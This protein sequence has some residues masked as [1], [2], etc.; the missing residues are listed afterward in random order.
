MANLMIN[1]I[2]L[3]ENNEIEFAGKLPEN[4]KK[5][6]GLR[7]MTDSQLADVGWLPM[8]EIKTDYNQKTHYQ[9]TPIMDIQSDKIVFTDDIVAYTAQELKRNKYSDW[10]AKI[11]MSDTQSNV[12]IDGVEVAIEMNRMEERIIDALINNSPDIL[13]D[14]GNEQLKDRFNYKKTLRAEKPEKPE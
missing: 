13:N 6:G 4:Y 10:V 3:D 2:Y 8:V 9:E 7:H 14:I 5:Q 1:Y 11:N 12:L